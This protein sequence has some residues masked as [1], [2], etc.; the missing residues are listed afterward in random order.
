VKASTFKLLRMISLIVLLIGAAASLGLMFNAGRNQSSVL[1][2]VLFTIWV[3][4]PF[5]VL[6]IVNLV[7]K[8][9]S[10]AT[11]VTLCFLMLFITFFSLLG[12]RGIL[13]PPGAKTAFKFLVVPFVSWLLIAIVILI[14]ELC[15]RRLSRKTNHPNW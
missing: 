12:Y 9:W 10:P 2:I 13:D 15:S 8:P 14:T 3:L 1:L 11:R 5:M 7:I 6:I 4:S